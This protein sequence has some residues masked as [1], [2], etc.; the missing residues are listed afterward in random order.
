M[1]GRAKVSINN[2]ELICS[3]CPTGTTGVF[4]YGQNAIQQ[5]FGNGFRCVGGSVNRLAPVMT[6]FLGDAHR[7]IDVNNLRR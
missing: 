3:G 1:A 7:A 4:F 5:P 2:F 6:D